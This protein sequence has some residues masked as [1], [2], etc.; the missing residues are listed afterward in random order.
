LGSR[1]TG[2]PSGPSEQ[3]VEVLRAAY[4]D[5]PERFPRGIPLLPPLP[6]AAWIN[7]PLGL[8]VAVKA[9]TDQAADAPQHERTQP[10]SST[11]RLHRRQGDGEASV[12][13]PG[14]GIP[15]FG[16]SGANPVM[17]FQ[18][19]LVYERPHQPWPSA[20]PHGVARVAARRPPALYSVGGLR[21]QPSA[22]RPQCANEGTH[23][24]RGCP[25]RAESAGGAA[26]LRA[27]WP[28]P[29]RELL[30]TR[31]RRAALRLSWRRHQSWGGPLHL[32]RW[33]PGRCGH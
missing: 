11:S 14:R 28:A 5:H 2:A 32:V 9:P 33:P 23:G 31:R 1:R 24:A 26:A 10:S 30:G 4:A 19:V 22:H 15:C 20:A 12:D 25:P 27:L 8:D 17:L 7:K 13:P 29:A 18:K 6:T 21:A 16:F 3:H